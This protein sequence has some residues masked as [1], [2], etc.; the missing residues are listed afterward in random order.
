P[1]PARR[2]APREALSCKRQPALL[3]T[4]EQRP[5][6]RD[7]IDAALVDH[8]RVQDDFAGWS[9][10]SCLW[11]RRDMFEHLE[12]GADDVGILSPDARLFWVRLARAAGPVLFSTEQLTLPGTPQEQ[13]SGINQR[14]LQ[15]RAIVDRL[16]V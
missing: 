12:H 15:T 7:V 6:S 10:Q 9:T 4:Q 13:D 1:V 2:R 16:S 11:W 14:N 3:A 8:E 5:W